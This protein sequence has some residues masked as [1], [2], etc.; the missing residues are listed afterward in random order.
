MFGALIAGTGFH[1]PDSCW[2]IALGRYIFEHRSLPLSDPFS[3]TF[4]SLHRPFVLYQWGTELIYYSLV[5]YVG[6]SGLLMTCALLA[7]MTF[8][9]LPHIFAKNLSNVRFAASMISILLV[10]SVCFHVLIR[11]ELF[12]YVLLSLFMYW[13]LEWRR[14]IFEISASPEKSASIGSLAVRRSLFFLPPAM[15]AWANLH[16]GFTLG[17]IATALTGV[18]YLFYRKKQIGITLLIFGPALLLAL[19]L[20]NPFGFHLW[21]YLPSLYFSRMNAYIQELKPIGIKELGEP[22]F[23]PF[24]ILSA[25]TFTVL[26]RNWRSHLR[27]SS[28]STTPP[29]DGIWL[30]TIGVFMSIAAGLSA[31]RMIAFTSI[32]LAFE[33]IFMLHVFHAALRP[34][35][36]E[37]E[38]ETFISGLNKKLS[39][40][41]DPTFVSTFVWFGLASLFGA[42]IITTRLDAPTVPQ[43]SM[44]L[45][46]P[47]AAIQ[48]LKEHKPERLFNDA[49]FG[50]II[51]WQTEGTLPVF[52]DTR[53]DMYGNTFVRQYQIMR[54]GEPG[55]EKLFN[56][57]GITDV[58]VPPKGSLAK[59][60]GAKSQWKLVFSDEAATI[61][62]RSGK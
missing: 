53:Y 10:L 26:V 24:L 7:A 15:L 61:F 17:L 44:V 23:Y 57:Y 36:E 46:V 38:E 52:I 4:A 48:Y 40:L 49:Q 31:R 9:G 22:T 54:F 8:I 11:P 35:L 6:L 39:A 33:S 42:Y 13:L 30:S 1:D 16:S 43:P 19:T 3:Y 37:S 55:F 34:R 21:E 45:K 51:I 12:S 25:H 56:F 18:S 2:L 58:M 27:L 60:L 29:V 32:V 20:L 59:E 50:D 28:Q 14:K 62:H 5:K 47:T 41:F